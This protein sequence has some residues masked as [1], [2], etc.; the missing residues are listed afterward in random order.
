MRRLNARECE[1]VTGA[2]AAEAV[3]KVSKQIADKMREMQRLR[4]SIHIGG[5]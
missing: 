4:V 3:K 5:R 1:V 2:G